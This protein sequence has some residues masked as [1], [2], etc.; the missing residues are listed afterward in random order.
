MH[1][2]LTRDI[3]F[4][5]AAGLLTSCGR[6]TAP[7]NDPVQMA[8]AEAPVRRSMR[9]RAPRPSTPQAGRPQRTEMPTGYEVIAEANLFRPLG[10]EEPRDNPFG[11]AGIV[12]H[13]DGPRALVTR[14]DRPAGLYVLVGA[15]VGDG[16]T[17]AAID[18]RSV[19]LLGARWAK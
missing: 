3:A 9:G 1:M 5:A 12:Q 16:Y 10:W 13:P 17:V 4:L 6:A 18:G 14:P 8:V 2:W 11:L 19:T 15:D 7:S